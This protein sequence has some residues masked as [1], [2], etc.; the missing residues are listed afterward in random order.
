LLF[1]LSDVFLLGRA[2]RCA[3]SFL[4]LMGSSGG[5]SGKSVTLLRDENS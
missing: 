2:L 1:V 3:F 5:G 4:Y